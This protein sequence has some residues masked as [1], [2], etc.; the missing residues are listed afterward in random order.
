LKENNKIEGICQDCGHGNC[1][2]GLYSNGD[3]SCD[4]GWITNGT[5][6]CSSCDIGFYD[7]GSGGCSRNIPTF[8]IIIFLFLFLS[9][10]K[11]S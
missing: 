7:N 8:F 6:K 3:C 11:N 10:S 9:F 4:V 2:D 5:S 1:L